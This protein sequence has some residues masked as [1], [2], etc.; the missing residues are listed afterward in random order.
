MSL[1]LQQELKLK[2]LKMW[3]M[4]RKGAG[5][6]NS[7]GGCPWDRSLPACFSFPPCPGKPQLHGIIYGLF[8]SQECHGLGGLQVFVQFINNTNAKW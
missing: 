5:G 8:I 2:T 7:E 6:N 1:N 3:Q 4:L